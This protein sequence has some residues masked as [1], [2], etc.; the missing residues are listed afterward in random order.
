MRLALM[1]SLVLAACVPADPPPTQAAGDAAFAVV[2]R[3]ELIV[4]T[5]EAPETLIARA[6]GLGY[7]LR[8]VQPLPDLDD[9][10]VVFGIPE[11]STIAQAIEEIERAVPG[12]TAGAHHLYRLQVDGTAGRDYAAAM[13]G[14]PAGGCRARGRVGLI[15]AGVTADHPGLADGR[16]AQRA[17]NGPAGPPVTDHGTLMAELLIG[18]DRLHGTTLYSANVVDPGLGAGDAAGVVAILRGVDWLAA[19]GVD[20][21][22][23]SLAGPRNKLMDRALGHA[24]QNGM[25]LVAAVGNLGAEQPPQ[26]PA[27]FPFALAVTAVDRDGAI[28]RD[29]IRGSHVDIAAPG[30]DILVAPGGRLTVSSGT[31][32]A[33]P[34]VTAVVASDPSL[35]ELDIRA[36]RA[37]LGRRATDLGEAGRDRVF[38]AGLLRAPGRC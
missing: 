38:G 33:A 36:L 18:P 4:L 32:L 21:V 24:A 34:Q 17:F 22:N 12:V 19:N 11:G 7:T 13:I 5:A 23:I 26:Y 1:L 37:E 8:D 30:V 15:D 28:Y 20:V 25:A 31:S 14:W 27:A 2:D 10:L 16:I 6:R 3:R 29:A 35:L 9:T